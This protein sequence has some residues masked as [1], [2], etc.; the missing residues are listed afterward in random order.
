MVGHLLANTVQ[1]DE[2]TE[3]IRVVQELGLGD[4]KIA[5]LRS[6]LGRNINWSGETMSGERIFAKQ[7]VG[8]DAAG[9]FKRSVTAAAFLD[10]HVPTPRLLY[11]HAET[12]T[13]IFAVPDGAGQVEEMR[14]NLE[15]VRG[16]LVDCGRAL[17]A[18]HGIRPFDGLD[19]SRFHGPASSALR[20]VPVAAYQRLSAGQ[21]EAFRILHADPTVAD[22]V[23]SLR[24]RE[25]AAR[26]YFTPVHGDIRLD[27]FMTSH[28]GVALIDFEE[29]RQGDPARDLG[30]LVGSVLHSVIVSIPDRLR[31]QRP[32][33]A[34]VSDADIQS[35]GGA[36][37]ERAA[38]V[39]RE[40]WAAYHQHRG[41]AADDAELAARATAFGG[42]HMFDRM[43]ASAETATSLSPS[44][45]AAA[46]IGRMLLMEPDVHAGTIGLGGIQ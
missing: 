14:G 3:L 28:N 38:A 5:G 46:G 40:I 39:I 18:L 9:R 19:T 42:W 17:A 2:P 10:A 33:G 22:S 6:F 25:E 26:R 34:E 21:L 44:V 1:V 36:D 8:H 37:L 7:F 11:Q 35:A 32:I 4:L 15:Q 30:A 31:D 43:L 12:R 13:L 16:D 24:A 23:S 45:L 29:F 41:S 27:Q 20:A